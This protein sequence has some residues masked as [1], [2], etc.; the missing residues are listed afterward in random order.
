M[1]GVRKVLHWGENVLAVVAGVLLILMMVITAIDVVMRYAFNA[2]LAWGFDLVTHYMLVA[3]F[4]FSFSIALRMG[5]HVAVDYFTRK[6]HPDVRRWAMSIAW[7]TCGVLTALIAV[8]SM[9]ETVHAWKQ[10]EIIAGVIPWPV[11]VQKMIVALGATPLS[12]RLL[13]LSVGAVPSAEAQ[14]A[15]QTEIHEGSL[16]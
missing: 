14:A 7:G 8:M 5:E 4:F 13:L 3:S 6:F 10:A 9:V 16:T 12:L 1:N 11:W 2:P 15:A